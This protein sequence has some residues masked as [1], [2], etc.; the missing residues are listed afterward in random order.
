MGEDLAALLSRLFVVIYLTVGAEVGVSAPSTRAAPSRQW[1]STST[2][3]AFPPAASR[4][5]DTGI[6]IGN[7]VNSCAVVDGESGSSERRKRVFPLHPP[8]P[9]LFPILFP[10]PI[11]VAMLVPKEEEGPRA[12][13]CEGDVPLREEGR[14]MER[15]IALATSKGLAPNI[16]SR[17]LPYVGRVP[18]VLGLSSSLSL[19]FSF[20]LPFPFSFPT[21]FSFPLSFCF[22]LP[23]LWCSVQ[24]CSL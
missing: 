3:P 10:I 24:V 9:M 15:W 1:V 18:Y 2:A 14:E 20:P 7:G 22:S 21:S 23:W 11:P 8:S 17:F 6:G 13:E 16:F 5:S 4:F 12:W 19:S